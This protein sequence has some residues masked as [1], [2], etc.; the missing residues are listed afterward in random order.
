MSHDLQ[1]AT[2]ELLQRLIRFDTVNP[3]GNERAAAGVPARRADERRLRVR[4]ARRRAGAAEPDRAAAGRRATA[5]RCACSATSTRSLAH[6][7][8]WT[9]DPWS[10]DVADGFLWGRGALDMKSQVAA[11]IAAAISLARAGWRPARGELL[12]CSRR[13]RGDR[14]RA[15]RA[16]DHRDASRQGP[17]RLPRQRGRRPVLRVRR[18]APLRRLLRGEGRLPLQARDRRRRR[19]RVDAEDGRQRAAEARRRCSSGSARASPPT[20][21]PTCRRAF[22]RG[23]GEDPDDPAGAVRA[24]APRPIRAWRRCSSRC[25]ASRSR[26]RA[27]PPPRRST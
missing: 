1:S 10:G 8:E 20:R 18:R 27:R 5:R 24:P 3:P 12:I 9:H 23:L 16:V 17:L 14:R 4:A 25:S 22:L 2:T 19:A 13:R 21:S 15:R 6:P 26:R 7:H 11:E